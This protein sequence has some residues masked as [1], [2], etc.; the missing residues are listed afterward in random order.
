MNQ[1]PTESASTAETTNPGLESAASPQHLRDL[2]VS[3]LPAPGRIENI[4]LFCSPETPSSALCLFDLRDVSAAVVAE[5][6]GGQVFGFDS[7]VLAI[8]VSKDFS[9]RIRTGGGV[10]HDSCA[11]SVAPDVPVSLLDRYD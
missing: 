7:V 3:K 8:P 10:P 1:F 2:L 6:I 9:C 4:N 11:C 5:K